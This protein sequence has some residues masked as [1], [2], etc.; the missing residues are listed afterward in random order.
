MMRRNEMRMGQGRGQMFGGRRFG[1]GFG[2]QSGDMRL[3]RR[4]GI[5]R[6]GYGPGFGFG[7]RFAEDNQSLAEDRRLTRREWLERRKECLSEYLQ[8][9]DRELSDM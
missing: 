1:G 2:R 8:E 7:R 4:R 9:I 6:M 3:H 5:C